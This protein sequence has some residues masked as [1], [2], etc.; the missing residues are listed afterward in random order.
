MRNRANVKKIMGWGGVGYCR[1]GDSDEKRSVGD[2][3]CWHPK[4]FPLCRQLFY[5]KRANDLNHAM[6]TGTR[7]RYRVN[8]RVPVHKLR[9][10]PVL[11][12]VNCQRQLYCLLLYQSNR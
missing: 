8:A 2:N 6:G 4:P 11:S 10:I 9:T 3:N 12:I 1:S 5:K 7:Y